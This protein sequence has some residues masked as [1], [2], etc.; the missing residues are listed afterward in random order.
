MR[1]L[2]QR[3]G[4]DSVRRWAGPGSAALAALAPELGEHPSGGTDRVEVIQAFSSLLEH[5]SRDRL[6]W[7][8]VEDLQWADANTLDTVQYVV[9]LLR[10]PSRLLVTATRRTHDRPPSD[11]FALSSPSRSEH[12]LP[13]GSISRGWR[14]K[15]CRDSSKPCAAS[16]PV[17]KLLDRAMTLA[18]GIPFLTEELV[19]SGLTASG[20]VDST[21]TDLML[22]RVGHCRPMR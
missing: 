13:S 6:T 16:H 19:A 8:L 2:I 7:W 22:A 5:V 17:R 18:E 3:E 14:V 10:P 15:R 11:A 12:R 9:H 21:V 20:T 4:L 1:D